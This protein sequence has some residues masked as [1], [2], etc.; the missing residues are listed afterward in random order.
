MMNK[1]KS[2]IVCLLLHLTGCI[3]VKPVFGA[4]NTYRCFLRHDLPVIYVE[5][6]NASDARALVGKDYLCSIAKRKYD[7]KEYKVKQ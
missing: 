4:T 7:I 1:S 5:A 6:I 3:T 2:L